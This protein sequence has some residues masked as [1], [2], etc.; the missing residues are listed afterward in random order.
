MMLNIIMLPCYNSAHVCTHLLRT[1]THTHTHAHTC[2]CVCMCVHARACV[3]THVLARTHAHGLVSS[4]AS[5]FVRGL[6]LAPTLGVHAPSLVPA[7]V[8][9]DNRAAHSYRL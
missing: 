3:G 5:P 7:G 1:C 8:H 2:M 4:M 9:V 6:G